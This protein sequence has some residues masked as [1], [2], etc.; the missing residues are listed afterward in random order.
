MGVLIFVSMVEKEMVASDTSHP[1]G[2]PNVLSLRVCLYKEE[3]SSE[4]NNG[5]RGKAMNQRLYFLDD[6]VV[7]K[8]L[9]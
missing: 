8:H 3:G 1:V 5:F 6:C 4:R 9:C 2:P 7:N